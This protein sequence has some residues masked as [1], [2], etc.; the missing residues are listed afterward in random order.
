M[1]FVGRCAMCFAFVVAIASP[2]AALA[3]DPAAA[4]GDLNHQSS[5]EQPDQGTGT[6]KVFLDQAKLL[7]LPESTAT[8]VI[9]NPLIADVALQTGGVVVVTGKGYGVTNLL[10]LDRTGTV[11]LERP[12]EVDGPRGAI[13][14]VYRG[15]ER[16]SYS[17]TPA[18]QRR[19]TLGDAP[20]YFDAT[21]SQAGNLSVQAQTQ[22]Q[23]PA[24]NKQ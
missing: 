19:I 23:P 16:E 15:V 14:V 10:A 4:S 8:L 11:L 17:C 7:K 20:S 1:T 13:V 24:Q 3:A 2:R 9:G 21:L 12:I 6:V 22:G 18:C 5:L